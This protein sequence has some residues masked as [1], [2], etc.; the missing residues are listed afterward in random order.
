[1]IPLKYN[2]RNLNARLLSTVMTILAIGVVIAVTLSMLALYNG[3]VSAFVTS[4]SNDL[5]LVMLDGVD[6][7][8]SSRITK[9][10]YNI[11]RVL[12]G[13]NAASPEIVILFKLPKKDNPKGANVTVRGV[14]PAAFELRP[15]V[16]LIEGRMFRPGLNELIVSRRIRDRFANANVGDTFPIGAQQWSVVGVFDAGGTA[17]DSEIWCDAGYLGSA[18]KRDYFSSVL[19]KPQSRQSL[20]PIRSTIENDPRLKFQVHTEHEYYEGSTKGLVAIRKLV[21]VVTFFMLG[22][23]IFGTMNLMFSAVSSRG[24]ELATLRAVGFSRRSIVASILIESAFVAFVGGVVG[25]LLA[26]PLNAISTGTMNPRTMSEVAFSFRVDAWVASI[27]ILIAV[28][29]GVIG[30]ILP[31]LNAAMLPITRALREV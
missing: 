25:V 8:L 5:L 20:G 15:Y 4:G 6:A 21:E 17:F 26:T 29:A 30:G 27:G 22:A 3:V 28:G 31:A 24:R 16:R 9:D 23:A 2:V 7:E 18:R 11:I 1:M 13:V 10:A 12:P 14:T 19:V